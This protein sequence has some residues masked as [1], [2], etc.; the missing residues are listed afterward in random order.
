MIEKNGAPSD[1]KM[2]PIQTSYT[3]IS[4]CRF[5]YHKKGSPGGHVLPGRHST[6]SQ[7]LLS[8]CMQTIFQLGGQLVSNSVI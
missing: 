5:V 7:V 6:V 4:V 3:K 1:L 8:I 2:V